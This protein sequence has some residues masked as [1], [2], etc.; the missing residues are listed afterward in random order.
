MNSVGYM[1]VSYPVSAIFLSSESA[2]CTFLH[3]KLETS[4]TK[5]LLLLDHIDVERSEVQFFEHK[6][7]VFALAGP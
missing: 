2:R 5:L 7:N 1:K 4:I 3:D 6:S